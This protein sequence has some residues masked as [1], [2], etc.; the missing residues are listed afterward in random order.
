MKILIDNFGQTANKFWNY[1]PAIKYSLEH[2]KK[3][4]FLFYDKEIE[5]FPNLQNNKKLIF[6]TNSKIINNIFGKNNINNYIRRVLYNRLYDLRFFLAK[7]TNRFIIPFIDGSIQCEFNKKEFEY[8]KEVFKPSPNIVN[9]VESFLNAISDKPIIGVHM[10]RGDYKEWSGGVYCYDFE[11]YA[12]YISNLIRKMNKDVKDVNILLCSNEKIPMELFKEF[13]SFAIPNSSPIKDLY[14]LSKC[15][16]IIGPPSTFSMWASFYG[17]T[18]LA[19]I[20]NI[21]EINDNFKIVVSHSSN[22]DGTRTFF[23]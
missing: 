13:N 23:C 7:K 2:N 16:Y 11:Q 1:L 15:D 8:V 3:V 20:C 22:S 18:R 21:N 9:E 10:R 14:A 19:Y 12:R 6:P 17:K 4:Y 5:H